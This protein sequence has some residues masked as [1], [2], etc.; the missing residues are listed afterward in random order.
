MPSPRRIV[1][2][3]AAAC[4]VGSLGLLGGSAALAVSPSTVDVTGSEISATRPAGAGWF[5]DNDGGTGAFEVTK[6]GPGNDAAMKLSLL[7]T[8]GSAGTD[9]IYL[10]NSLDPANRPT[11]IPAL[12]DGA[13]YSYAGVNVNFQIEVIFK[14][15]DV[16]HYGPAGSTAACTSASTWYGWGL[17][18]D[19]DWCYTVLKWE[20]FASSST[21][22]DVD[23]DQDV[24]ASATNGTGGWIAQKRVGSIAP[25]GT[26]NGQKIS[27]ILAQMADYQVTGFVFGAGGGTPGPA[28]G[29][30]K[31]YTIGGTTYQFAP[32]AAAAAAPPAAD[33][34]GLEAYIATNSI[35]VPGSTA[36]FTPTGT[37]NTDLSK[38][39]STKP[40]NGTY[41]NWQDP[42]DSFVDVYSYST[43]ELVGTFPVVGSKVFLVNADV[44][45]LSAGKHYLV[46]QGQTSGAVG[47]VQFN[48]IALA[49][50]G[51]EYAFAIA[52]TAISL[53][54]LGLWFVLY[55]A[56][57]RRR[58]SW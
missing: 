46:F 40:L 50:T 33:S 11:D 14:P 19:T 30:V 5:Y 29:W 1:A 58:E 56:S 25:P 12:L 21:W 42:T 57:A 34:A 2:L 32:E 26:F 49:A 31:S 54:A 47:I 18:S 20:P 22:V 43:A 44:S 51:S 41:D 9:K 28:Y 36:D 45:S 55:T 7:K 15:T 13:S 38:I 37:S 53:L 16:A 8:G 39:D 4:L 52:V 17:T 6:D 23:L 24:A 27:D 3:A 35:D 48:V 10:Y